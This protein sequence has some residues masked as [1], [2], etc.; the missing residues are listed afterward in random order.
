MKRDRLQPRRSSRPSIAPRSYPMFGSSAGCSFSFG[1]QEIDK[2]VGLDIKSLEDSQHDQRRKMDAIPIEWERPFHFRL[3][4][5]E[6]QMTVIGLVYTR[7]DPMLPVQD[8]E[9]NVLL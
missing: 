7:G 2:M 1:A 3:F 6:E 8:G 9:Q 5:P 4:E